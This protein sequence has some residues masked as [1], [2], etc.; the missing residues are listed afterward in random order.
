MIL[1]PRNIVLRPHGQLTAIHFDGKLEERDLL[2]CAH[3]D[4]T[5]EVIPG[6]G[7]KRGWCTKCSAPLCGKHA[8]MARCTPL[9]A[10]L[11]QMESQP[12]AS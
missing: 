7:R 2:T 10:R 5:W 8:C 4:Y 1:I 3:C 12:R 9:E 11:A 6:S